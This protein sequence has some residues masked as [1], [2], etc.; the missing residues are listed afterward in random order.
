M[1]GELI[2]KIRKD[3][4]ISKSMLARESHI[5]TGH[6]SHIEKGDRNP[7]HKALKKLCDVLDIPYQP[8]MYAYDKDLTQ[9]Q[10]DYG[11]IDRI[12]Y[13]K[14]LAVNNIDTLISCP[15]DMKNAS[16]AIRISD[17]LME[18]QLTLGAYAF[19]ELNTPLNN[20]D[21]GLFNYK[22]KYIF[23]KLIIRQ[24]TLILRALK[25]GTS[26]IKVS[27]KEPLY[28]IGKVLGTNNI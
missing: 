7:S 11:I 9:E 5:D 12:C 17:D 27:Y 22:N 16:I 10:L 18:P 2:A 28:I 6:L 26:D 1:L 13:D 20:K 8:L 24:D 25:D 23:R 21:I 3:K 15:S 19:V 4:N 14:I